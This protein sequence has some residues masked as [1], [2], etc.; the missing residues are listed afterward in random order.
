MPCTSTTMSS[1]TSPSSSSHSS[2]VNS[3]GRCGSCLVSSVSSTAAS[4][5]T[6]LNSRLAIWAAGYAPYSGIA[7]VHRRSRRYSSAVATLEAA[8]NC[9]KPARRNRRPIRQGCRYRS[10]RFAAQMGTAAEIGIARWSNRPARYRPIALG[11]SRALRSDGEKVQI[12]HYRIHLR[13]AMSCLLFVQH[14]PVTRAAIR[15]PCISARKMR[16]A[17]CRT[18]Q[19]YSAIDRK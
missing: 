18:M 2:G 1:P 9:S 17:S 14:A 11:E 15:W 3:V 6:R 5:S 19:R 4:I 10:R 13:G 8:A 7:S 16:G 12:D